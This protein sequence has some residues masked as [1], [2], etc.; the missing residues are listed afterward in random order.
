MDWLTGLFS[1]PTTAPA[2]WGLL[3]LVV[4]LLTVL[5]ITRARHMRSGMFI[6]GGRKHRLAVMDAT[7][8][9]NRR[10]LVLVRRDDVEH[11]LLI[12]GHNDVVVEADIKE[13]GAVGG[14]GSKASREEKMSPPRS[15]TA[16][17]MTEATKTT[18]RSQ[19]AA[20]APTRTPVGR[21][22]T[23]TG[24]PKQAATPPHPSDP[25]IDP[26]LD[27]TVTRDHAAARPVEPDSVR[28]R[29]PSTPEPAPDPRDTGAS[30][31][32]QTTDQ[33]SGSPGVA[34]DVRPANARP[35]KPATPADPGKSDAAAEQSLNEEMERLLD[36]LLD[37][38]ERRDR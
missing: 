24:R 5:G 13:P 25:R 27:P 2:A 32:K 34:P 7:A 1:D 21:P 38:P 4:L 8:I 29:T 9:D 33:P 23:P 18:S 36:G 37:A 28:P 31:P 14:H 19:P 3:A 26:T 22:A 16:P 35:A 11:L 10:R 30:A 12:G 15:G 6:A 20:R 17:P